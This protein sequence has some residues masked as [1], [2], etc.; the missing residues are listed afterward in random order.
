MDMHQRAARLIGLVRRFDLFA[1]RHRHGRCLRLARQRAGDGGGDDAGCR[2]DQPFYLALRWMKW[3]DL[4]SG[5]NAISLT[6]VSSGVAASGYSVLIG[7][8]AFSALYSL[9]I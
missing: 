8:A 7:P 5:R 4:I 1:R 2:H 3:K 6:S 9:S